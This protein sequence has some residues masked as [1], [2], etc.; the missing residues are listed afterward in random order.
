V[1]EGVKLLLASGPPS[2]RF[3]YRIAEQEVVLLHDADLLPK[4]RR[5][6]VIETQQPTAWSQAEINK[7]AKS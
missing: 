6:H 2:A 3:P 5:R 1:W 7:F 4:R